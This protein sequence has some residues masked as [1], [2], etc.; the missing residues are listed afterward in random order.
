MHVMKDLNSIVGGKIMKRF[1]S[2]YKKID[3]IRIL[4]QNILF[5]LLQGGWAQVGEL[6][7]SQSPH[8]L[9]GTISS[10][11]TLEN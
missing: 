7:I 11:L 2:L 4:I 6:E 9:K 1:I 3:L 8:S 5:T 10:T